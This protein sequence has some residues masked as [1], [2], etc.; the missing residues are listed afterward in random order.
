MSIVAVPSGA[1]AKP[2]KNNATV[3]PASS[4]IVD[5]YRRHQARYR[6]DPADSDQPRARDLQVPGTAQPLANTTR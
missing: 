6:E 2:R 4:M 3:K 1:I 5:E